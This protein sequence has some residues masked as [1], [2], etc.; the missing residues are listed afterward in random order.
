MASSEETQR[1]IVEALRR[2]IRSV[3]Q[4]SRRLADSFGLTG[5]QLLVLQELVSAGAVPTGELARR[6]HLA[7]GT[8]SEIL[9]RL[10]D[11][12]YVTRTRSTIDK[13]RVDCSATVKGAELL[14][15]KP[16]LLQE[17]FLEEL[18][19]LAEWER[20]MLLSALQR[21]AEMMYRPKAEATAPLSQEAPPVSSASSAPPAPTDGQPGRTPELLGQDEA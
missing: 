12:G 14:A 5:P 3:D 7:Q 10:E 6:I 17:S 8:T 16:S 15:R 20:A 1:K 11:Q 21:V 9:D 2:I 13:R 18:G 19:R 4:H